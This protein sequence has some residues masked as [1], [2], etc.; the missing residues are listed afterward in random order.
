[1]WA[2]AQIPL[3]SALPPTV[4]PSLSGRDVEHRLRQF[5]RRWRRLVQHGADCALHVSERSI[6]AHNCAG[7]DLCCIW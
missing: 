4:H 7:I 6:T 2:H 1:M 5:E 3:G